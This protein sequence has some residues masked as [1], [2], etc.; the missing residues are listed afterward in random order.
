MSELTDLG[1]SVNE[2]C[3][4]RAVSNVIVYRCSDTLKMS[5]LQ[6]CP[7]FKFNISENDACL[8]AG[9]ASRKL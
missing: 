1:L 2:I 3:S 7:L 9:G 6:R 5:V 4:Y 8:K